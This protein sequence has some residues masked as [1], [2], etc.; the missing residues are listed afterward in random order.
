MIL[1]TYL[2][3]IKYNEPV[4]KD[5]I[6]Y[7]YTYILYLRGYYKRSYY[8]QYILNN[9]INKSIKESRKTTSTRRLLNKEL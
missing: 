9:I 6:I 8:S 5:N 7:N 4:D 1:I 2:Y 3:K